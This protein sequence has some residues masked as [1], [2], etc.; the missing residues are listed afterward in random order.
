MEEAA[1]KV[2]TININ[3]TKIFPDWPESAEGKK[4]VLKGVEA[5]LMENQFDIPSG[6]VVEVTDGKN[7]FECYHPG[8]KTEVIA[9]EVK[10]SNANWWGGVPRLNL[11]PLTINDEQQF[12]IR[13]TVGDEVEEFVVRNPQEAVSQFEFMLWETKVMPE[14]KNLTVEDEQKFKRTGV[15]HYGDRPDAPTLEF[16][17]Q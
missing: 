4:E 8:I 16:V 6:Q 7:V 11:R 13:I 9:Y 12:R 14:Y 3:I 10:N 1:D 2:K 15:L 5:I 17:R